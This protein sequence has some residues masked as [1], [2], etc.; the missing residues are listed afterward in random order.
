MD[1]IQ[2]PQKPK[3]RTINRAE[4]LLKLEMVAAGLSSKEILEQSACFVFTKGRVLTFNGQIS[5]SVACDIGYEG[6]VHSQALLGILRKISDDTLE[7]EHRQQKG[8]LKFVGEFKSM[9]ITVQ[10]TIKLPLDGLTLPKESDW[11]K[12]EDGFTEAVEMSVMSAS[13]DESQFNITCVHISPKFVEGCDNKQF[14]R[15]F[16]DTPVE[17]KKGVLVRSTS[18]R[19]VP[20]LEM[21]EIAE[22]RSW[23]HFRNGA[24]LVFSC[25]KYDDSYPNYDDLYKFK[26]TKVEL[27]R[28]IESA[29][30]KASVFAEANT[31]KEKSSEAELIITLTEGKMRVRGEGM[32]GWYRQTLAVDYT[33]PD[34]QFRIPP[35][36]LIDISKRFMRGELTEGKLKIEGKNW[37][38][39]TA[40]SAGNSSD[41]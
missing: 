19:H 39:V 41:V 30:D 37:V 7:V 40:L 35:K 5:C 1:Q 15:Y 26:G 32:S 28:S 21:V 16:V 8:D 17:S 23:I 31:D 3:M 38:Y 24:G 4:L 36:L 10:N 11:K 20:L 33:G 14:T 29:A 9:G 2:S 13:K 18:M 27:P 6:A 12:L 25:I 34:I 22:T